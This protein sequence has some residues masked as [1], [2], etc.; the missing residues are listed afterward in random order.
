MSEQS[1]IKPIENSLPNAKVKGSDGQW[2]LCKVLGTSVCYT[3]FAPVAYVYCCKG[4][5]FYE[6][7]FAQ[8]EMSADKF[9]FVSS[10]ETLPTVQAAER[11]TAGLA[12]YKIAHGQ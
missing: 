8:I 5:L 7:R 11:K 10:K 6:E 9:C 2:H 1:N 4:Y 3:T 12:Y